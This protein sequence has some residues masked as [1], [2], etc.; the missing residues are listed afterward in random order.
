[1]RFDKNF[2]FRNSF[3]LESDIDLFFGG[4]E[5]IDLVGTESIH[6]LLV[7]CGVF[8]S[9]SQSRKMWKR[10]ELMPGWNDFDN[11]GK[12]HNRLCVFIPME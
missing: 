3:F 5:C 9:K 1:M 10:G 6:D 8:T 12:L 4:E 2:V 11:I 7:L